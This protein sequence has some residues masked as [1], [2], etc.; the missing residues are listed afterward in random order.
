MLKTVGWVYKPDEF[1]TMSKFTEYDSELGRC[2]PPWNESVKNPQ[3][4][5]ERWAMNGLTGE[6]LFAELEKPIYGINNDK[7]FGELLPVIAK[8]EPEFLIVSNWR[9]YP[10]I[11]PDYPDGTLF[12]LR[13]EIA[14]GKFKVFANATFDPFWWSVFAPLQYKEVSEAS[15]TKIANPEYPAYLQKFNDWK[16]IVLQYLTPQ[17]L[18]MFPGLPLIEGYQWK[19]D[20][21]N[22]DQDANHPL[23]TE[24]A[25]TKFIRKDAPSSLWNTRVNSLVGTC[26]MKPYP[27]NVKYICG[28]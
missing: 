2:C 27:L 16:N 15:S 17:G 24:T 4:A 3:N 7:K 12:N 28:I 20:G 11:A 14:P 9:V 23:A 5:N 6:A 13:Q 18:Y 19:M 22:I 10:D 8:L 25:M 1:H 26:I 21:V